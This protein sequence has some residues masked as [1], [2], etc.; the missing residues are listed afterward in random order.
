GEV[1]ERR[2]HL[3]SAVARA[4]VVALGLM[5]LVLVGLGLMGGAPPR[6]VGL[7]VM[8]GVGVALTTARACLRPLARLGVEGS[9]VLVMAGP[10]LLLALGTILYA[11]EA[12]GIGYTPLVLALTWAL[13]YI[14]LGAVIVSTWR[15]LHARP[16]PLLFG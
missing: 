4:P 5:L 10:V 16:H 9:R 1:A 14:V 6:T 11:A 8:A 15:R 13:A 7:M 2:A 12:K 3:L